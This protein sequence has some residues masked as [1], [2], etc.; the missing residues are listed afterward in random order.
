[1]TRY[2]VVERRSQQ[3]TI[4]ICDAVLNGI[5]SLEFFFPP[6]RFCCASE[7]LSCLLVDLKIE[8]GDLYR[9]EGGT[10]MYMYV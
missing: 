7:S 8:L 3:N 1:M 9:L 4:A 6:R 5:L 2:V 10:S